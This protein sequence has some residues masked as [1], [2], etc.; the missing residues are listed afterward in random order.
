MRLFFILS[1]III[2]TIPAL[3]SD[4]G[5][6]LHTVANIDKPLTEVRMSMHSLIK[7]S[8]FTLLFEG[9]I[10]TPDY[11]R[12]DS[13]E[14]CGYKA[15]LFV[16]KSDE[17]LKI[18]TEPDNKYLVAGFLRVGI[19]ETSTGTQINIANPETINRI[20]FNDLEDEPYNDMVKKSIIW[21]KKMTELT[22]AIGMGENVDIEMEPIRDDEDLRDASRDMFMMVGP[23][24][25]FQDE[26]QFPLIYSV[27]SDDEDN[28]IS[29][30]YAKMRENLKKFNP[31]EDDVD[32]RWTPDPADLQWKI[33]SMVYSPDSTA[34][35][36]GITRPR[37]EALSFRIAGESRED[38]GDMCPGIDHVTAYPIEVLIIKEDDNINVY[39]AREMLRMDMYFWDAGKMAFMDYMQMP[40]MLNK[41]IIRALLAIEE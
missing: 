4:H 34:L 27:K 39:T 11:V 31:D 25:F 1:L 16:L 22:H 32:Y 3:A 12:E 23:L 21:R 19:Y 35:M 9:D 33:I 36:F 26:D 15:Y 30:L 28:S 20:I 13:M 10:K 18:I 5:I 2:F 7:N 6:Y 14:F 40:G 41:S 17:Y 38:G 8:E 29:G 37:T 24:T